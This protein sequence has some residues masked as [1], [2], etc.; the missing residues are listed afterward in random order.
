[1]IRQ[2]LTPRLRNLFFSLLLC[3]VLS[4]CAIPNG[5]QY[6]VKPPNA[7]NGYSGDTYKSDDNYSDSFDSSSLTNELSKMSNYEDEATLDDAFNHSIMDPG[8][9]DTSDDIDSGGMLDSL[10]GVLNQA[11]SN[12]DAALNNLS[13]ILIPL[14]TAAAQSNDEQVRQETQKLAKEIAEEAKKAEENKEDKNFLEK[15]VETITN[16]VVGY[17][18]KLLSFL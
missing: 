2:K 17:L 10:R 9:V 11:Q 4:A 15:I 7:D 12:P 18:N 16:K 14:L 6:V 5:R 1:M 8:N 3:L 13:E